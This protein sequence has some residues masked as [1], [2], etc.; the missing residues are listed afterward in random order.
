M[1]ACAVD[2]AALHSCRVVVFE[3]LDLEGRKEVARSAR[4]RVYLWRAREAQR[5]AESQ[6]HLL[7]MRTSRVNAASD[8]ALALRKTRSPVHS[9]SGKHANSFV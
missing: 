8:R 1:R 5:C 2:F 4:Q 6:A 3:R 9:S 7:G